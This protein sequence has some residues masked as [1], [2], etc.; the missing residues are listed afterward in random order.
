MKFKAG[1]KIR[2]I[3][4]DW[5]DIK[6]G[7]VVEVA[8]DQTNGYD[9]V[10]IVGRGGAYSAD[11]FEL[12]QEARPA[13]PI[14]TTAVKF[15]DSNGAKMVM[16]SVPED[17]AEV[18]FAVVGSRVTGAGQPPTIGVYNALKGVFPKRPMYKYRPQ[19]TPESWEFTEYASSNFDGY[20]DEVL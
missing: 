15:I 13:Q 18:L 19:I 5:R 14:G 6:V 17:A 1:D 7:D 4:H 11:N 10:S 12:V 16:L 9:G 3:K 2:R 8:A 20:E